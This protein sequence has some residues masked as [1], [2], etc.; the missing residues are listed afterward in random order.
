MDSLSSDQDSC[1]IQASRR[2]RSVQSSTGP[3]TL[4]LQWVVDES[5][6]VR[7]SGYNR[8]SA[9]RVNNVVVEIGGNRGLY[10]VVLASPR[11]KI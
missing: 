10:P 9:A 2:P 11:F 7:I 5:Y 3:P 1:S 4:A 6:V 8:C